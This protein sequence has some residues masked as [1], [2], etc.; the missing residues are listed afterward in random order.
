MLIRKFGNTKGRRRL[1][2]ITSAQHP[3]RDPPEGTKEDQVDTIAEQMKKHGIKMEC[4]IFREQG[5]HHSNVMEENDRLLY[6]FRDLSVAKV[7][8]VDSP[9]SILG[10]LR[11]RNVLP[12][13]VFRGDL[14]VGSNL[15]IKVGDIFTIII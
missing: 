13:T 5:V 10:A 12:V 14:E 15:K 2:L 4:I 7:V 1:C 8:K 11:T 3:L 6:Q 9:T